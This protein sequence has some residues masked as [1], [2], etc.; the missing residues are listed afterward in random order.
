MSNHR[1]DPGQGGSM[2]TFLQFL[3]SRGMT[4]SASAETYFAQHNF[5]SPE[6][7]LAEL[8]RLGRLPA[9]AVPG[10]LAQWKSAGS[11]DETAA[12]PAKSQSGIREP[13]HTGFLSRTH[14][15][16]NELGRGAMGV[17]YLAQN[18]SLKRREVI[19]LCL[20]GA[21][22]L[23]TRLRFMREA[24]AMAAI[25]HPNV[26]TIFQVVNEGSDQ[27]IIMEYIEGLD[28]KQII[29]PGGLPLEQAL[30]MFRSVLKGVKAIHKAEL[31][32]RDL[33]PANIMVRKADGDCVVMDLGLVG[34]NKLGQ[35][36]TEDGSLLGT[37][38]Y[39]APEQVNSDSTTPGTDV[40]ALA[41]I[42][43]ELI[44]GVKLH[45]SPATAMGVFEAILKPGLPAEF[46]EIEKFSVPPAIRALL[47]KGLSHDPAGRHAHAGEM[48][49]DLEAHFEAERQADVQTRIELNA[50]AAKQ[51]LR[52][53]FMLILF[54]IV[55][56]ISVL[57]GL[58]AIV[59]SQ[60]RRTAEALAKAESQAK[61]EAEARIET[62]NRQ[63][64][65]SRHLSEAYLATRYA[66]WEQARDE[67]F[68]ALELDPEHRQA[69]VLLAEAL[70]ILEDPRVVEVYDWLAEQSEGQ[71]RQDYLLQALL[72]VE[73]YTREGSEVFISE[74]PVI[75]S[76]IDRLEEPTASIGR[77][78]GIYYQTQTVVL[79]DGFNEEAER[80]QNHFVQLAGELARREWSSWVQKYT[81]AALMSTL[82]PERALDFVLAAAAQ[83]PNFH[84][85]LQHRA[86]IRRL[87]AIKC[88]TT[89]SQLAQ[90][91]NRMPQGGERNQAI[92]TRNN[93]MAEAR[94]HTTAAIQDLERLQV[95]K[96]GAPLI[97]LRHAQSLLD[98]GAF[99]QGERRARYADLAEV[100]LDE[101]SK[102]LSDKNFA[103]Y[104]DQYE[105]ACEGLR[106]VREAR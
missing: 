68:A 52:A 87:L 93:L 98:M 16:E 75:D 31:V 37:P 65:L 48:L 53:K 66:Q 71:T 23:E 79:R 59:A 101:C 20:D 46:A 62:E 18:R 50:F 61:Q 6:Q 26:V 33:K 4:L 36:L 47:E 83:N 70:T 28:L 64:R 34:G 35:R 19:K 58:L 57:L 63:N 9:Q 8:V 103:G 15:I 106:I 102:H 5:S 78:V 69:H 88:V 90:Q 11:M 89:A 56:V 32:H 21:V 86:E 27:A 74:R 12:G 30:S 24:A 81:L 94:A 100:Q 25:R 54:A 91:I 29:R 45:G 10:L 51:S 42:G 43:F 84:M 55:A 77:A 97:D 82:D 104:R 14:Q 3:R 44:T 80:L 72:A 73:A 67:L 38:V 49:A 99:E 41:K 85:V 22:D 105:Q 95:L 1:P 40:Y 76:I 2:R 17:V 39:M 7:V 13:Q 60:K 92:L 96:P